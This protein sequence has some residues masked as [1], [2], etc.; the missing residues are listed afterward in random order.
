M[1]IQIDGAWAAVHPSGDPAPYQYE[2]RKEA[3]NHPHALTPHAT[4]CWQT[5]LRP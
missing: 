1:Q 4:P 2:T 3:L 5:A